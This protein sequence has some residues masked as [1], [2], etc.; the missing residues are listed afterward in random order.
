MIRI[1]AQHGFAPPA[2][3]PEWYAK[4]LDRNRFAGSV[5]LVPAAGLDD[6]LR[7]AGE[8]PFIRRIVPVAESAAQLAAIPEHPLIASV[9]LPQATQQSLEICAARDWS[10]ELP[11][12]APLPDTPISIVLDGIPA[13]PEALPGNVY[14]KLT[15]FRLPATPE[16][17]QRLRAAL[18]APGPERLMFATG[19][20]HAGATWKETLA[21]FTQSLGAMPIA[22]REQLLGG[23]ACQFYG[24]AAPATAVR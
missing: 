7:L 24:I 19:W 18:R 22:L 21:A 3:G 11:A 5:Y 6:A 16:Q 23:T 15:G 1:D 17:A 9:R 14:I 4:I 10:L 2:Q 8:H 20:P 13:A 12:E